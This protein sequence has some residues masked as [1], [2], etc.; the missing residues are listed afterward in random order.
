VTAWRNKGS[1]TVNA[2]NRTGSCTSGNTLA[3]RLNF[4]RCPAGTDMEFTC[5]LNTQARSWFVV[6]RNLTQ[7]NVSPQNYWGPIN[8]TVSQSDGLVFTRLGTSDYRGYMGPNGVA[9]TVEMQFSSNPLNVSNIYCWVN[10]T[11][12]ASNFATINGNQMTL[13]LSSAASSFNTNNITYI[14][15]TSGYNTGA[16]IFEIL[17]FA[18][19]LTSTERQQVEGY[20]AWKWGLQ[21]SLP[22]THPF[23]TKP[24]PPA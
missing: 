19:A 22:A 3:N 4:I 20:L 10:S 17:F 21:A 18:R 12:S 11:T 7:L 13:T 14:L 8:A 2:V 5:S 15:N 23:A 1:I 24:P 6:A 16:D 9:I